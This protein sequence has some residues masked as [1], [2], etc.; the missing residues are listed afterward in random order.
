[1]QTQEFP[2]PAGKMT[3]RPDHG[4]HSYVGA[5]R[6]AGRQALISGGDSGIGRAAAIA[7]AREEA[8]VA[9][10][11]LPVEE[12]DAEEVVELI[13]AA[14]R[15]AV[16]VP[17]DIRE[18]AFCRQLVDK[19]LAELGGL[20]ILVIDPSS[21]IIDYAS[22]K[23]AI[24]N[25]SKGLAKQPVDKGICVNAVA[26]GPFWTPLQPSCGQQPEKLPKFGSHAPMGRPGQPVEIA[27]LYVTLASE[28]ASYTTGNEYG[29][30]GGNPAP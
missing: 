29:A 5:G 3:P 11:Y 10:N 22:T 26:P 24:V 4:E 2:G 15:K 7:Y 13:R 8:D 20:D 18:E 17:G 27:A 16:G 1:M 12:P 19:A 6:L 21:D 28:E 14:G 30:T 23:A 25:F 9:I